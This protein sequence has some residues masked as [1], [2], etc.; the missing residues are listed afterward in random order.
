MQ[1][2]HP[3]RTPRPPQYAV[4]P[5]R[6]PALLR[7]VVF[8][9]VPVIFVR[10]RERHRAF[11]EQPEAARAVEFHLPVQLVVLE[12]IGYVA[13]AD[14]RHERFSSMIDAVVEITIELL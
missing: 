6:R 14:V 8:V 5:R 3:A 1:Q 2:P 10:G 7:R 12:E 4:A 13:H 11:C 9:R